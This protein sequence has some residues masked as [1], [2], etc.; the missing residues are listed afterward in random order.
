MNVQ[1]EVAEPSLVLAVMAQKKDYGHCQESRIDLSMRQELR[2]RHSVASWIQPWDHS[3]TVS[4][5][6][7]Q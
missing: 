7:C 6:Q 2:I 1:G 3:L 4:R 5:G